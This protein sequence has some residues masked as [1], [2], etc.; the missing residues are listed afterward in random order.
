LEYPCPDDLA[1]DQAKQNHG[2]LLRGV[3]LPRL[4]QK[5]VKNRAFDPFY[6]CS[7]VFIG[8]QHFF[9]LAE[10]ILDQS[11]E[12]NLPPMDTDG[13]RWVASSPVRLFRTFLWFMKNAAGS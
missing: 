5:L 9:S 10:P 6:R 8:G 1:D 11:E 2:P 12:N 7:S 13:H 3:A 4:L